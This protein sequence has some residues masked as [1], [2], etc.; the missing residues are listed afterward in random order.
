VGE[1]F[2]QEQLLDQVQIILIHA[3]HLL[4]SRTVK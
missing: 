4:Y 1:L 2:L 3:R